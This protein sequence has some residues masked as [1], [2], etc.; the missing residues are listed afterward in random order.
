MLLITL[1][2]LSAPGK[3]S[4]FSWAQLTFTLPVVLFSPIVGVLVDIWSRRKVMIWA[5]VIQAFI[6]SLTPV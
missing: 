5:H 1:V 6:L 4:A 3:V 2:G